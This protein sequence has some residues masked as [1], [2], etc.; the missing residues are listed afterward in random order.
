MFVL[1]LN[2]RAE[3]KFLEL[4]LKLYGKDRFYELVI[5][6]R[7]SILDYL[8]KF[9]TR[10]G[11]YRHGN[12]HIHHDIMGQVQFSLVD[13]IL[14]NIPYNQHKVIELIGEDN[15]DSELLDYYNSDVWFNQEKTGLI[16]INH[17][18]WGKAIS[19]NLMLEI[20]EILKPKPLTTQT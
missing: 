3:T 1:A 19:K 4:F 11:H 15:V 2:S 9:P 14:R 8:K 16:Y 7:L 5:A 6:E 20:F 12:E 13:F 10:Q 17:F 18:R